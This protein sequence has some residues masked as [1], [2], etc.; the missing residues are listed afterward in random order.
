MLSDE[1]VLGRTELKVYNLTYASPSSVR[2][3]LNELMGTTVTGSITGVGSVNLP[4][5]QH[6]ELAGL[7]AAQGNT[8]E[9]TGTVTITEN[10]RL[11][12]LFIQANAVDHKTITKLIEILD[13][14]NRDDIMSRATPRQIKLQY[15]RAEEAK[16]SVEQVFANQ[17]RSGQQGGAA[18]QG[19]GQQPSG[20]QPGQQ[21]SPLSQLLGGLP[22]PPQFQGIVS[23]LQGQGRGG[24]AAGNTA[25]EQEP[26]MTLYVHADTNTLTVSSTEATFLLVEAYVKEL[27]AAAGNK[28]QE[29][30]VVQLEH[31]PPAFAK[32]SL[33]NLLGA[34]VSIKT[35]EQARQTGGTPGGGLGGSLGGTLG[36]LGGGSGG[37]PNLGGFGGLGGMRPGGTIGGGF[38]GGGANP[39]MNLMG[40][41]RPGGT[42]GG[43][44]FGG[45]MRPGGT[46]G[47]GAG[48][49]GR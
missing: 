35:N 33:E 14:P 21:M 49:A 34:A 17:M 1:A 5:W 46:I 6:P 19:R 16:L 23:A 8:I 30:V 18:N 48:P 44:T 20:P 47:G 31:A 7:F 28:V 32:Q 43:G 10:E 12:A 42:I 26:T 40:G 41:M 2:T 25:R 4:E 37:M 36:G 9:K 22:I 39:F 13:Q 15:M 27:D 29:T 24:N 38:F 3:A 45:G 11:C